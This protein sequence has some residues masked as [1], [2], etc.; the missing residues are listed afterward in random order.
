MMVVYC[1]GC[2]FTEA[3]RDNE[4]AQKAGSYHVRRSEIGMHDINL[5]PTKTL[6]RCFTAIEALQT[7]ERTASK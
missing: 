4:A 6:D 5:M 2:D 1:N 7:K 3:Y